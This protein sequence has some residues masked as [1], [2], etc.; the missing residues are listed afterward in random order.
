MFFLYPDYIFT[1]YRLSDN[2]MM[3]T[4]S[5]CGRHGDKK[6]FKETKICGVIVNKWILLSQKM[7]WASYLPFPFYITNHKN[8]FLKTFWN[9]E[10][11]FA[12]EIY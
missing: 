5:L 3:K 7:N 12:I 1:I 6:A 11:K 2:V 10:N 4:Y 8:I 9:L